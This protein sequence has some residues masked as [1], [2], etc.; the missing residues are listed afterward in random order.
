MTNKRDQFLD[1]VRVLATI[2]VVLGHSRFFSVTTNIN[3]IGIDYNDIISDNSTVGRLFS[4]LTRLIYSCHMQLFICLS[5]MVFILCIDNNKYR[6][7]LQMIKNRFK[8]LVVPYISVSICYCIPLCLISG[9]FNGSFLGD[10]CLYLFGF[11]KN[12]LWFLIALFWI[13]IITYMCYNSSKILDYLAFFASL[14]LWFLSLNGI[15]FTEFL[16]IDRIITYLFWFI[17]GIILY[18]KK[19]SMVLFYEKKRFIFGTVTIILFLLWVAFYFAS[20]KYC[21]VVFVALSQLNGVLFFVLLCIFVSCLKT[22]IF[23][24]KVVSIIKQYSFEIYL[25][26]T[27][28]NY[29]ILSIVSHHS[30]QGRNLNSFSSAFLIILRIVSQVLI[31]IIIAIIVKKL[32]ALFAIRKKI[33]WIK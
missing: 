5:G 17:V 7:F 18:K 31:P 10:S 3:T 1:I 30:E 9:Y 15:A 28:I 14:V 32:K 6:S 11:G 4:Y 12:H 13:Y 25:Y 22:D 29:V 33:L 27:P 21:M 2:L 8:R 26:A 20:V 16:Y 24:I 19:N 23:R